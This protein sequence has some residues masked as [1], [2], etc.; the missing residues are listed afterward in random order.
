MQ[1]QQHWVEAETRREQW[2]VTDDLR[3]TFS[4]GTDDLR[5]Y[6]AH[7]SERDKHC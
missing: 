7:D 5:A 3:S 1:P 2:G 4:P 6:L